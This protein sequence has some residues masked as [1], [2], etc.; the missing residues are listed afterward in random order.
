M[1]AI[2]C[3]DLPS[4][5][6]QPHVIPISAVIYLYPLYQYI[7]GWGMRKVGAYTSGRNDAMRRQHY[8]DT[9]YTSPLIVRH[10][11]RTTFLKLQ[12][13]DINPTIVPY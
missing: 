7:C 8:A 2:H 9:V 10:M 3:R 13:A 12:H 11:W 6:V 1:M 5:L 4:Q